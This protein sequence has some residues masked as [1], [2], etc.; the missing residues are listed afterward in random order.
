MTATILGLFRVPKSSYP[1]EVDRLRS[2]TWVPWA[3]CQSSEFAIRAGMQ[4][5]DFRIRRGRRVLLEVRGGTPVEK[6]E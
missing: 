4:T 2:G 5:P 1:V 6:N 3:R